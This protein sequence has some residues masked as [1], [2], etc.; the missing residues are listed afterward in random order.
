MSVWNNLKRWVDGEDR[1]AWFSPEQEEKGAGK[2]M[3]FERP[4][5]TQSEGVFELVK[6]L[7]KEQKTRVF[8]ALYYASCVVVCLVMLFS[9]LLV[10]V[11]LPT[12]GDPSNPTNNELSQYY[13]EHGLEDAGAVNLVGNMILSYR[14]FDTFGESSVLFLATTSVMMLMLRDS[15]TYTDKLRRYFNREDKAEREV[16]D[17]LLRSC[18]RFLVPIV[19]TFGVYVI[20]NGHL[21][22]G[23]GFAGG[24]I[25]G[26]GLILYAQEF[27]TG[28][29]SRYFTNHLYH[30]IK[31]T[32]LAIYGILLLWYGYHGFNGL[33]NHI[34]LGVPGT[35]L[36]SGIIM[37]INVAVG[38]EVACTIYAFYSL[39]H[40][41]EI[42]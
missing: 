27:G 33:D 14:V 13:I 31:V 38:F 41:G 18:S 19:F 7:N 26:G 20:F 21:S 22:P 30:V 24:S 11:N 16:L 5:L 23:G 4:H 12:F 37:P 17:H 42:K 28:G 29:V 34:W 1:S 2:R 36:S 8:N 39:F 32:A 15:R 9:L 10:M 6:G 40:K 3:R 25:L 35:I